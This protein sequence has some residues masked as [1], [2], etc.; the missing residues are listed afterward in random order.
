LTVLKIKVLQ[1][2]PIVG[3]LTGNAMIIYQAAMQSSKDGADLLVTPELSLTGYPP[4]DLLLRNSFLD[5]VKREL[6]SLC[7]KLA[8][9]ENLRVIVGHP[10]KT[11]SGLQNM[12]SILFK[13]EIVFSYAKQ[14]LPNSEVFDEVRYFVPGNEPGLF[15]INGVIINILICED[16]WHKSSY[17][18]AQNSDLIIIINAS[19]FHVDKHDLRVNVIKINAARLD[20]P[21]LYVNAVG[22]QDELVFD[23]GS[24]VMSRN[25]HFSMFLPQFKE[26][27]ALISFEEG[28]FV[29]D[30]VIKLAPIEQQVYEALVLAVKDYVNKNSFPGIILGLSGGVDSALV[31]AVAYDALGPE[32]VRAV[33]M[34]SP[35]TSEMSQQDAKKMADNLLVRYDVFDISSTFDAIENNFSE[36]FKGKSADTTEENIQARI[37]GLFLMALSNK[38]GDLVLTT[39]NKSEMAVGYCTLYGD[40]AGGFAVLKDVSKTLVYRLC[41]YRNSIKK[42]I[43]QRILERAP[44]AELKPDQK[45]EDSLPQYSILDAILT[46]Y[47][48]QNKSIQ[49]IV[50]EGFNKCDVEKITHLIMINEYKRRQSAVGP[51]ITSRG[52]GRD[53]RYPI[54]NKFR[55]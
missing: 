1:S 18:K 21:V 39:G 9:F 46:R 3:D 33:M 44:S 55:A 30:N 27:S 49:S 54:T 34:P 14:K 4:E 24:F 8:H 45:D 23:G 25:K 16:A 7:M 31:L 53:W 6:Q 52:F 35:Y 43:P 13:G 17:S 28:D 19:P 5:Q 51:R 22:G 36:E 38:F 48:E 47:M 26:S 15:S 20:L 10:E 32:R 2:N 40:M 42:I 11:N 37:R 29:L 12:A 50:D 41:N